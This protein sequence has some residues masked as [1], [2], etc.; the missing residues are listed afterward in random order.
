VKHEPLLEQARHF[1]A[2]LD[3]GDVGHASAAHGMTVVAVLEAA[4]TSIQQN[5]APVDVE[6]PGMR[7]A[8]V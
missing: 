2:A 4:L 1:L 7:V 5:G 6:A 8:A 3:T